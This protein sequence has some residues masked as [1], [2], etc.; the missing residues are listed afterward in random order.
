MTK[1]TSRLKRASD[2]LDSLI[3]FCSLY[4]DLRRH[5]L[6]GEFSDGTPIHETL[7]R[8]HTTTQELLQ[9]DT[10]NYDDFHLPLFVFSAA[11]LHHDILVGQLD[12]IQETESTGTYIFR[13]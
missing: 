10:V 11:Q 1:M 9:H 5:G 12:K 3:R 6:P 2:K 7:S 8:L 13:K 4:S